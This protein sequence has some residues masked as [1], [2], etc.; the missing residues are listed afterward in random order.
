MKI[1]PFLSQ[2]LLPLTVGCGTG[3]ITHAAYGSYGYGGLLWPISTGVGCLSF[4][5]TLLA[6]LRKDRAR[7]ILQATLFTASFGLLAFSLLNELDLRYAR[8]LSLWVGAML[9]ALA[10]MTFFLLPRPDTEPLTRSKD[11]VVQQVIRN[12]RQRAENLRR[13]AWLF[14]TLVI[15]SISAALAIFVL[16]QDIIQPRPA[17]TAST[18]NRELS[19]AQEQLRLARREIEPAGRVLLKEY[20]QFI[21]NKLILVDQAL[22]N[23]N[24]QETQRQEAV[25]AM[26]AEID[27]L[28]QVNRSYMVDVGVLSLRITITV[29][30]LFLVRVLLQAYRDNL[31]LAAFYDAKGDILQLRSGME[32]GDDL[33]AFLASLH[34]V[35]VT[36]RM[37]PNPMKEVGQAS[38]RLAK[39]LA[40][41]MQFQQAA[42]GGPRKE[43][44]AP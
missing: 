22:Q 14:L 26:K 31:S 35:D 11:P 42:G 12:L 3:L 5:L 2:A 33:P 20:G 32:S 17:V 18:L 7:A 1:L 40:Q 4:S 16:A 44:P 24:S 41:V 10:I 37:P 6:V 28:N 29:L 8:G 13:L 21:I 27:R 43:P 39:A 9:G 19:E 25:L 30:V 15:A 38:E 23:V 36:G 34:P